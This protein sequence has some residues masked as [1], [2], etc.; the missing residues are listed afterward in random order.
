VHHE[1]V[2]VGDVVDD[3]LVEAVGEQVLGLL[4]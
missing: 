4:V 2:K 1:K 3:E